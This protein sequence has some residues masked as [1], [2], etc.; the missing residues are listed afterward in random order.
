MH[1]RLIEG[2]SLQFALAPGAEQRPFGIAR[3]P[4]HFLSYRED[5]LFIGGRTP[6]ERIA[7][8]LTLELSDWRIGACPSQQKRVARQM[9][10]R[11]QI[12]SNIEP[13]DH[14]RARLPP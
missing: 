8:D 2:F 4:G 14:S 9:H 3:D 1:A 7:F 11:K 13:L 6:Q 10:S 12:F 5:E